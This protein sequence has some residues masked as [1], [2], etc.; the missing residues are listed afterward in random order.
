MLLKIV[1]IMDFKVHQDMPKN[2]K[3]KCGNK[4]VSETA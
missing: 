2:V 4:N 3:T 1:I